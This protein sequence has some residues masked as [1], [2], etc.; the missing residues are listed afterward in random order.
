MSAKILVN[1]KD[2]A[3]TSEDLIALLRELE[4]DPARHEVRLHGRPIPCTATEFRLLYHLMRNVGRVYSR[5]QL[6][7]KVVG[8]DVIVIERNIDVHIS[9]LRRKLKDYGP[10]IVTIRGVGYKFAES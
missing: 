4:I 8:N 7:E 2:R 6:L 1:G 3:M 9:A 10:R 5:P